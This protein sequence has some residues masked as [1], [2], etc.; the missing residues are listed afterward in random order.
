MFGFRFLVFVSFFCK[1]NTAYEMRISYWSSDVCSSALDRRRVRI[2]EHDAIAI[3]LE[4]LDRLRP[5]IIEFT[6]LPDDD[7]AGANDENG[8]NVGAFGHYCYSSLKASLPTKQR[9]IGKGD[10]FSSLSAK[11]TSRSEERRVGKE[12]VSK[13]ISMWGAVHSKK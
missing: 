5:R 4:R 6:R 2:D 3:F 10:F 1:H 7:R 8:G 9:F 13:C 12:C 11:S